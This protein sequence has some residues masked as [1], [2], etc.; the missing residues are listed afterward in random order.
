MAYNDNY[1]PIA[2]ADANRAYEDAQKNY[3][4]PDRE[5]E[6]ARRQAAVNTPGTSNPAVN[7][8]APAAPAPAQPRT[9]QSPNT[10]IT[11]GMNMGGTSP[12]S[13]SQ[14]E[15]FKNEWMSTGTDVARQNA[16]LAKHGLTPDAAGRVR[17]P[18]GE[19]IDLR[20]GAKAGR[21]L[22]AWTGVRGAGA[23]I[24][25][26]AG[27]G[28]YNDGIPGNAGRRS[29]SSSSSTSQTGVSQELYDILLSRARQGT[30]ID[31]ND[32]NIRQQVE[33]Y[34]AQQERARRDYLADLAEQGGSLANL[35]G[36][37]RVA[38]ERAGQA[39]GLFESQLIGREL[40]S[41]RQEIIHALDSLRGQL[42]ADQTLALQK[43]LAYLDDATK[44]FGIQTQGDLGRGEL[45]L[46]RDRLGYDIGR[47]DMDFWLRGQGF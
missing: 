3:W 35:R 10:G 32:P 11:G 14:R 45:A 17:L 21:N 6:L 41:R 7:P 18:T 27:V 34:V 46:G 29:S 16:L 23:K 40:D 15:Q 28:T 37:E 38:S 26:S 42:T 44:R 12:W 2:Q 33:P 25:Q 8:W 5:A 31:R 24:G 47:S 43:E 30:S 22:A 19:T 39:S 9:T 1:D 20:I 4:A 36:E 13:S